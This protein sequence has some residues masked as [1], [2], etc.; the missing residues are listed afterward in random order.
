LT[1]LETV[2]LDDTSVLLERWRRECAGRPGAERAR[3][4]VLALPALGLTARLRLRA[5]TRP[6]VEDD[7]KDNWLDSDRAF[8]DVL[9]RLHSRPWAETAVPTQCRLA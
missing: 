1:N 2:L 8:Y 6:L 3:L 4:L 9:Y 7:F 5:A